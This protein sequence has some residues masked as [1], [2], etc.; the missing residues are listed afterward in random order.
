ME[1]LEVEERPVRAADP[2]PAPRAERLEALAIGAAVFLAGGVLLGVEIAASRVL[3]PFFGN[4][5]FVWGALIGVVLTGLSIGYWLGGALADRIEP[6]RLLFAVIALGG[7]LILAVPLVDDRVLEWIVAWNPGPRLNPLVAAVALFGLPSVVIA[8]VTPAAVRLRTRS[9]ARVGR[10]A[11]RLFSV[12]TAGSIAGTF[13]TAFFLIP[14]FGIEQLFELAAAT[15]F[16]AAA[17]VALLDRRLVAVV[18]ALVATAGAGY[19]ALDEEAGAGAT[20]SGAATQNW[21]PFYRLRGYGYLDAHDAQVEIEDE[22]LTVVHSDDTAYHRLAVVEDEDTR[23]LR[24]DA[25]LQ[26]AMYVDDP[27]R[28]RFRYTDYFHLGLA[29]NP[30]AENVLFVGLGAGSSPKRMLA[31]FPDLELHAVEIDPVV[32][33]VAYRWFELPQDPRLTVETGDGRQLLASDERRW[34]VIAIDAFFADAIP[35]HL[36]TREFLELARSRLAPGGVVVTNV[37]GALEGDGSRL[38]RSVYKTYRSVFPSV[39]VH[40]VIEEGQGGLDAYRNLIVV[41]GESAPASRS[42]LADRW[43]ELRRETPSVPDLGGAIEER[44]DQPIPTEDVPLLTDDY[45]PTDA[46]LFLFQ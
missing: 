40:P 15:L 26:S 24:F 4:S 31:D 39:L 18:A 27:L 6:A 9:L 14:E 28:T 25:S 8:G 36:V 5:L 42:V 41:A 20:V 29:Y 7:V 34:D 21:S 46:L 45:A 35:F 11:G 43:E 13:A 22:R 17:I 33:D 23:Y 12:S 30:G 38:F 16:V 10:T 2:P 19:L 32:V 44:R 3:A 37:I 1:T